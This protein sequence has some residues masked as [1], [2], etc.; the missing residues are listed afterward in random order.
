MRARDTISW[1]PSEQALS[2]GHLDVTQVLLYFGADVKAQDVNDQTILFRVQDEEPA[3]SLLKHGVDANVL[4][5]DGQTALHF[6]SMYGN[7]EVARVL[8]EYGLDVSARDAK[9]A[10]P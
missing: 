3:R 7:V 5:T 6:A 9:N 2:K 1:S 8:L 10:T 4:D